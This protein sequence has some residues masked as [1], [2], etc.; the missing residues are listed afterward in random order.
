MPSGKTHDAVT[1][2]LAV[3][4][5]AAAYVMTIDIWISA[6]VTISF[7]FG[8]FMFGPDLDTGSTQYSR[9]KFL[10]ILWFPYRSFFKHRSRWSHGMIFGTFLRVVYFMGVSTCAAIFV[11]YIYTSFAGRSLPSVWEFPAVWASVRGYSDH[12][13]GPWGIVAVFAGLWS[14]AASHKFTHMAGTYIKTGRVTEF[15]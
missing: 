2:I 10:K 3:P 5:F 6:V 11:A 9:W 14:G 15:L 1:V 13:L 4:I 8:G 7:L 12:L